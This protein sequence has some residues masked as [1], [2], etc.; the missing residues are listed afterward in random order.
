MSSL[1][2]SFRNARPAQLAEA[3][4]HARAYT[5]ALLECAS[6]AGLDGAIR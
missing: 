2:A 3:L 6:G 5:R 4:Q 1:H